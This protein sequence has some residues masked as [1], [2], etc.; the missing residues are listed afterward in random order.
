MNKMTLFERE[1]KSILL[2]PGF[3]EPDFVPDKMLFRE[4]EEKIISHEI[5]KLIDG[6]LH[7]NFLIYGNPGIGK[8]ATIK[9]ILRELENFTSKVKPCYINC[10]S[11]STKNG[12]YSKMLETLD[13][14]TLKKGVY[15]DELKEK[16][17]PLV[18]K[19]KIILILDDFNGLIVKK[20]DDLITEL[21]KV[22]ELDKNIMKIMTTN[23]IE[24]VKRKKILKYA[25]TRLQELEFKNYSTEQIIDILKLRCNLS[26]EKNSWNTSILQKI[27]LK[28]QE[29]SGNL[30]IAFEL[31]MKSARTADY[32]NSN[33]IEDA[34]IQK[35]I[36]TMPYFSNSEENTFEPESFEAKN[37]VI[38][39]DELSIIELL[40]KGK[41]STRLLYEEYTPIKNITKRQFNNYLKI[42]EAKKLIK[43]TLIKNDTNLPEKEYEI[44]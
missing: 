3:L 41:K 12:I 42:L 26:L 2:K 22:Q 37:K 14:Y 38:S 5:M 6:R 1:E 10:W 18:E 17:I 29:K 20:Q 25:F 36:K 30:R 8:T 4:K 34:D 35:A 15:T 11:T 43:G 28:T 13:C 9:Y 32:R 31:L 44:I 21:N 40:K 27:A 19:T 24:F 16:L 7:E 39:E 33:K 23:D